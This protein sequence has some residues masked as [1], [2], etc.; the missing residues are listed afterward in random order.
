MVLNSI[1]YQ[2]GRILKNIS[3][4]HILSTHVNHSPTRMYHIYIK[5]TGAKAYA[6]WDTTFINTE[7]ASQSFL[8]ADLGR[9][10]NVPLV[11]GVRWGVLIRHTF[12]V[13]LSILPTCYWKWL[14]RYTEDLEYSL[15][16]IAV[17]RHRLPRVVVRTEQGV[18]LGDW[19]NIAAFGRQ[20]GCKAN[21]EETY[22][23]LWTTDPNHPSFSLYPS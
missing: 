15:C 7:M 23:T 9:P 3:V 12:Y 6:H 10:R 22:S 2:Y 18:M 1:A 20:S 8:C 4:F 17:W 19:R 14:V 21:T 13:K 16:G 11:Q 5:Q